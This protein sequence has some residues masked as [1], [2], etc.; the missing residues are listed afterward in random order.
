MKKWR[1]I[2]LAALLGV[3]FA[4]CGKEADRSET[5][6][7]V[8]HAETQ[9]SQS[10]SEEPS[11]TD[12]TNSQPVSEEPSHTEPISRP[13]EV[14]DKDG[15][16]IGEMPVHTSVTLT[17]SCLFYVTAEQTNTDIISTGMTESGMTESCSYHLYDP[18]TGQDVSFGSIP[19]QDYEAG[20]VRTETNGKLYTLVTTGNALDQTPD[21]LWL[22]EF[23]LTAHSLQ[24]YKI[25]DNG[26]PYTA[27]TAVNGRLL[28]LNHD[29]TD[30]L[31][32]ILY[33]FDPD[34]RQTEQV[35]TFALADNTGD[36]I[37]QVYS[38]GKNVYLLRLHFEGEN[39]VGMFL[40]T[41]D[42]SFNKLSERE[43]SSL[44]REAAGKDLV[45]ED[46]LNEMK[47]MVSRFMVLDEQV[48]YY[49]NFSA[50]RFFGNIGNGT[51]FEETEGVGD[52]F[53]S[54]SGSGQPF[55]YYFLG[56]G[57]NDNTLFEWKDGSLEK[58]VFRANDERYYITAASGSPNG[59]K[60][61]QVDYTNPENSSDS[62]PTKIY[63]F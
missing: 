7:S 51:L 2:L 50:T 28:I 36:T 14:V 46:I 34:S 16:H 45:Q 47:Q 19:E 12:P 23:D 63:Y 25:S 56:G 26:F 52:M 22:A 37:R 57:K 32:D 4:G 3:S 10:V 62:L 33:L 48:I 61:I 35:L 42:L 18:Q 44:F 9:N 20:Y 59:Q 40:D 43:I 55:F 41:S 29:Q 6:S 31:H 11:H 15:K 21:P 60:L 27:M 49:E 39:T 38:D 17:D 58:T 5:E 1:I 13:V 54:A 53:L 24:Q 30:T 8:S